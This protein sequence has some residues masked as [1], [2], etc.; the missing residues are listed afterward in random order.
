MPKRIYWRIW[1]KIQGLPSDALPIINPS[2]LVYSSTCLAFCGESISP[3]AIIGILTL[4][5]ILAIVSYSALPLKRHCLVLPCTVSK[6][7]PQ[8]SAIFA[9]STPFLVDGHQPVLILRVTGMPTLSTTAFTIDFTRFMSF[10]NADP[11]AFFS[12]FLQGSP[13]SVSYTHL[14]LPTKA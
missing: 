5:F 2:A 10:S 11:A 12:T 9:T 3:F 14:T 1:S 7:T 6:D 4:C 13:Y 8:S